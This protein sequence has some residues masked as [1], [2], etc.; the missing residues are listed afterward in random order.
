MGQP[1]LGAPRWVRAKAARSAGEIHKIHRHSHERCWKSLPD[2]TGGLTTS[3]RKRKERLEAW[4]PKLWSGQS[5]LPAAETNEWSSKLHCQQH[6]GKIATSYRPWPKTP[7]LLHHGHRQANRHAARRRGKLPNPSCSPWGTG[8]CV[9][10][11]G[12]ETHP[13]LSVAGGRWRR[14]AQAH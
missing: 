5:R 7:G 11:Q 14:A 4:T 13:P 9:S 1:E 8:G 12:N 3:G 2:P 10:F 6:R